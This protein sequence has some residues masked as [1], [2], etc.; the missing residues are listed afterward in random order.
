MKFHGDGLDDFCDYYEE[1]GVELQIGLCY[2]I[3]LLYQVIYELG[4]VA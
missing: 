1:P 2:I 3:A 4:L